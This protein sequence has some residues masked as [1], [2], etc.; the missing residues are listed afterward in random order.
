MDWSSLPFIIM[1]NKQTKVSFAVK[2]NKQARLLFS[3]YDL[4]ARVSLYHHNASFIMVQ[5]VVTYF[6]FKKTAAS[7]CCYCHFDDIQ[8]N[9]VVT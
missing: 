4:Q 3:L 6:T 1:I 8:V 5:Y 2:C 9:C 7:F